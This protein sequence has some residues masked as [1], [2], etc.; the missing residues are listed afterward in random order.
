M[1]TSELLAKLAGEPNERLTIADIL[2]ALGDRSFALLVVIL[3]LRPQG[4]MGK[5]AA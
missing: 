2:A 3:A 1:R 4:L 5:R